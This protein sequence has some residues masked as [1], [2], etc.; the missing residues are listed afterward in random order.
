MNSRSR[1][2]SS[3]AA[4]SHLLTA[5]A[6]CIGS[7]LAAVS[8]G[9]RSSQSVGG[10]SP[11]WNETISL[12]R[13]NAQGRHHNPLSPESTCIS[14]LP[15]EPSPPAN[16]SSR[17]TPS[18]FAGIHARRRA[19]CGRGTSCSNSTPSAVVVRPSQPVFLERTSFPGCVFRFDSSPLSEL[20]SIHSL[21]RFD[22]HS[23][24]TAPGN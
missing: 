24:S 9:G 21:N 22:H 23:T 12:G 2:A 7:V 16:R 19:S 8:P 14:P 15:N 18:A 17:V 11:R 20:R 4:F 5:V 1:A 3:L 6:N 10:P 13:T